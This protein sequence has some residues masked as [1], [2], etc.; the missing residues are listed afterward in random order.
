MAYTIIIDQQ[1][2]HV[3]MKTNLKYTNQFYQVEASKFNVEAPPNHPPTHTHT[4]CLD[5]HT[6]VYGYMLP[7]H[8]LVSQ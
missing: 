8:T 1:I 2:I 7:A 4:Q 3:E 5:I 6:T